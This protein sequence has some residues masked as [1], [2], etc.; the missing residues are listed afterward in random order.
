M[1]DFDFEELDKA[2]N[3][4]AAK[5]ETEHGG[6]DLSQPTIIRPS[7]AAVA[8]VRPTETPAASPVSVTS[9]AT[10]PS[11]VKKATTARLSDVQ[12]PKGRRAFMDILPPTSRKIAPLGSK[13]VAPVSKPEDIVPEQPV[14]QPPPVVRH[15]PAVEYKPAGVPPRSEEEWPDPLDFHKADELNDEQMQV[16]EPQAEPQPATE[17]EESSQTP[18]LSTAKV[19]KRPLG[20]YSDFKPT[21][22]ELA[23]ESL[24][25]VESPDDKPSGAEVE[26]AK[27]EPDTVAPK[28]EEPVSGAAQ[29]SP[30]MSIPQQ[31]RTAERPADNT[32]RSVFDTKEYHPPLLE[33]TAHSHQGSM[34]L[35]IFL[36][37]LAL[38]IVGVGGYFIYFYMVRQVGS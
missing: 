31:Y 24:R 12:L 7:A 17:V 36:A 1:N 20:A 23:E 4:L 21:S 19:E 8:P 3:T 38:V 18:F 30:M 32:A 34:W 2:I 29:S 37:F 22:P 28:S 9:N 33:A 10:E 15:E 6:G 14:E 35:K 5:T 16:A 13:T 26:A 11:T 27:P 25:P